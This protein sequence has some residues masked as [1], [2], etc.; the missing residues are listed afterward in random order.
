MPGIVPRP[1]R[2]AVCDALKVVLL[3]DVTVH[4]YQND[5]APGPDTVVGDL[6]EAD[7]SGYAASAALVFGGPFQNADGEIEMDLPSHQFDHSGGAVA[8]VIF[9]YYVLTT[10]GDLL[11]AERFA[12]S[13]P[14][15]VITNSIVVL[16]RFSLESP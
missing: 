15:I 14:M 6:T 9:G 1:S 7:F 10:G 12:A 8:N 16:P 13:I 5:V 4:L 11:F 2:V 3:D